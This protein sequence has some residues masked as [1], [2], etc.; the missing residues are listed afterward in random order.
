[1]LVRFS[2]VMWEIR[3]SQKYSTPNPGRTWA[4]AGW[5]NGKMWASRSEHIR[6]QG[7]FGVQQVLGLFLM[8]QL[9]ILDAF[10][11][12]VEHE[13]ASSQSSG[14]ALWAVHHGRSQGAAVFDAISNVSPVAS[15]LG[16]VCSV[17]WHIRSTKGQVPK[18]P[19]VHSGRFNT[20]EAKAMVEAISNVSPV[21]SSLGKV[22]SV[23]VP[24]WPHSAEMGGCAH[25]LDAPMLLV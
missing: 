7:T 12:M 10:V 5:S 9:K 23:E 11:P 3:P 13:E 14:S 25:P 6:H 18:H 21:A 19:E 20:V 2:M 24:A 8:A 15:S 22:F 16:K 1:M 4:G 17:E